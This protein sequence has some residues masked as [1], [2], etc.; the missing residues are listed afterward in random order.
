MKASMGFLLIVFFVVQLYVGYE[1][2]VLRRAEDPSAMEKVRKMMG[3]GKWLQAAAL[4]GALAVV[5]L[6]GGNR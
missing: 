1:A 4:L 6:E 2:Y 5:L 3:F